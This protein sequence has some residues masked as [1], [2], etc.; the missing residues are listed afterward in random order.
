MARLTRVQQQELNRRRV[1]AAARAEFSERGFRKATVDDI[2]IR[3]DLTRGAVYSNFPGKRALYLA[4]LAEEAENAG[5]VLN[6]Y[7]DDPEGALAVFA[8]TWVDRLPRTNNYEY[9][10]SVQ[11][12]SPMLGVDLIPEILT[13]ERFQRPFAQLV[14]LDAILLGLAL[15]RLSRAAER[16][17][18]VAESVL[19]VLYGASELSFVAPDFVDHSKVIATC[20]HI[21][22][23][24]I[25]DPW[26]LPA[27]DVAV[28]SVDEEWAVPRATDVVRG[29]PTAIDDGIVAVVGMNRLECIEH[30]VRTA[31]R[32]SPVTAVL[33]TADVA[34]LAPLARLALADMCRSLRQAFPSAAWPRVQ[35]MVDPN[36]EIAAACGLSNVDDDTEAA[37]SISDGRITSRSIGP[38]A[39]ARADA[40]IARTRDH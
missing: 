4:V 29:K 38:G 2:A 16:M 21:T 28:N 25:D 18:G 5:E 8:S 20:R 30:L 3:S 31:P 1:L 14:K 23:I 27:T 32:E 19:T 24:V 33:V 6:T 35:V 22:G 10:G 36:G 26:T 12:T 37:V 9:Q 39:C 7:A 34:E 13:D 40:L 11:L 15:E 17:V